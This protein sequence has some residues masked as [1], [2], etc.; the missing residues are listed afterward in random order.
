MMA[1]LFSEG[2]RASRIARAVLWLGFWVAGPLVSIF[3]FGHGISP[4]WAVVA[5]ICV[6]ACFVE[7]WRVHRTNGEKI[8]SIDLKEHEQ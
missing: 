8:E 4:I 5:F 1:G 2:P 7:Y 3:R 6:V